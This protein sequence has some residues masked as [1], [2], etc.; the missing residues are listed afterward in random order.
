VLVLVRHGQS[1][2]NADG[3][4]V[5]RSD[6]AL[7]A[8]G[9]RQAAATAAAVVRAAEQARRDVLRVVTSP[10]RR[11]MDTAKAIC[12]AWPGVDGS[13]P[14]LV[15]DERAIELDYGSLE[16][17]PVAEVPAAT[18][19]AWR[20]DPTWRPPGGE[21]LVEVAGRTRLLLADLAKDAA[22]HDVVVVSHVSPIKAGACWALG[23]GIEA[24]WRMSL[25]VS[26]ITRLAVGGRRVALS[27]F[28]DVS[29][30]GGL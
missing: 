3:L 28:G 30:L 29:H 26:S 9:E 23:I 27:G 13:A 22:T 7:T 24:S 5:G 6:P 16:G 25:G 19:R 8:L 14:D 21:T 1:S 4:L 2:A 12:A 10:L 20:D 18:W 15:T 17:L 11:T